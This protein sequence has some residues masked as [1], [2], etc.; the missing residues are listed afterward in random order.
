[1][2]LR[3]IAPTFSGDADAPMTATDLGENK[4]V[5]FATTHQEYK[6]LLDKSNDL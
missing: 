2:L 1:M 5:K 6:F 3:T 4:A